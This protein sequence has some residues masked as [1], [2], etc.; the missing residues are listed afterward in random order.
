MKSRKAVPVDLQALIDT[1]R[2]DANTMATIIRQQQEKIDTGMSEEDVSAVKS[3]LANI[4]ATM[5]AF[6]D[7][8]NPTHPP[9]PSTTTET[10]TTTEES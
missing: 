10:T 3:Q 1:I 2:A 4:A 9:V 7:P 8:N 6:G 5:D